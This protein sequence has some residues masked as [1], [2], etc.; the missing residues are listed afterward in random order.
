MATWRR[1]AGAHPRN[2][3][4][5]VFADR[6]GLAHGDRLSLRTLHVCFGF[7]RG[8]RWPRR[9]TCRRGWAAGWPRRGG[10]IGAPAEGLG[11]ARDTPFGATGKSAGD[12]PV[13][14]RLGL[15]F[16]IEGPGLSIKVYLSLADMSEGNVAGHPGKLPRLWNRDSFASPALSMLRTGKTDLLHHP[17]YSGV[18]DRRP[19]ESFGLERLARSSAGL[20]RQG[21][22][23]PTQYLA[24]VMRGPF[25]GSAKGASTAEGNP[26]GNFSVP[27]G[28]DRHCSISGQGRVGRRGFGVGADSATSFAHSGASPNICARRA[29][30]P[31]FFRGQRSRRGRTPGIGDLVFTNFVDFR[32]C[33]TATGRGCRRYAAALEGVRRHAATRY[34]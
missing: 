27:L 8:G 4:P 17:R 33:C 21:L 28:R 9:A 30:M 22:G 23:R 29:A 5:A 10:I 1:H 13:M 25:V 32:T 24:A 15:I 26:P 2:S 18:P 34:A 6:S 20:L 3:A 14:F 12:R 11:A 16:P 19:E 7:G 31:P